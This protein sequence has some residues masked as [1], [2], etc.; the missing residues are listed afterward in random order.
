MKTIIGLES[1][2]SASAQNMKR[3]HYVLANATFSATK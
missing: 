3:L 2:Y 1:F